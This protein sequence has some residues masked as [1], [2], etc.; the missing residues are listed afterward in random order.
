VTGTPESLAQDPVAF[1]YG[2]GIH[3]ARELL[4]SW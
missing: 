2:A 1:T 3:G 4:V